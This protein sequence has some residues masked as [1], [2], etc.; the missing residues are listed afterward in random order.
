MYLGSSPI[1]PTPI[2]IPYEYIEGELKFWE[3]STVC[4]VLGANP[5]LYAIEGFVRRICSTSEIDKIGT[6]V[7]GVILVRLKIAEELDT[8]YESNG[9]LF[10]KKTLYSKILVEE[11]II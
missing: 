6:V 7:K 8:A 4:Y 11:Y 3:T 10:D 9:I 2:K 5:P 1:Y